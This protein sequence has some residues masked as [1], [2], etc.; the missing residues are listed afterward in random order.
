MNR[1]FA[2]LASSAGAWALGL[3][4]AVGA[5]AAHA[6]EATADK[7]SSPTWRMNRGNTPG[8]AMMTPEE[9]NQH[10]QMMM[11]MKDHA[12]CQTYMQEHHAKMVE[13]AK[14]R[15]QTIPA[16]PRRDAC[17]WLKK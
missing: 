13:R 10:H 5:T 17:G 16:T 6:Q 12:T 15:K 14:E 1:V 8:F 9:R 4:M 3:G 11:G 7:P 2:L